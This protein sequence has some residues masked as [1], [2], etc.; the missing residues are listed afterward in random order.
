MTADELAALAVVGDDAVPSL[1]SLAHE[2]RLAWAGPTV[3]VEG[4]PEGFTPVAE[5]GRLTIEDLFE[6]VVDPANFPNLT[7]LS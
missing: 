1:A 2:V 5:G 6:G 3:E 4:I 7:P